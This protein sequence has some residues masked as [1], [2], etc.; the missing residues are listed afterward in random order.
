MASAKTQE[1]VN[2]L[3][4][5]ITKAGP[6]PSGSNGTGNQ[7]D[8]G[9]MTHAALDPDNI[10]MGMRNESV[11]APTNFAEKAHRPGTGTELGDSPNPGN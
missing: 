5:P 3:V 10:L 6:V 1:G 7:A 11:L 2:A 8:P 9:T 4:N